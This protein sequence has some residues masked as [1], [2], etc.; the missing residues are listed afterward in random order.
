MLYYTSSSSLSFDVN[1]VLTQ[2]I[3]PSFHPPF[4]HCHTLLHQIAYYSCL[5]I[6]AIIIISTVFCHPRSTHS[7]LS[8]FVSSSLYPSSYSIPSDSV[9]LLLF[10]LCYCHHDGIFF[11]I[12]HQVHIMSYFW[13]KSFRALL[14]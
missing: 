8:T 9:L 4:I 3:L 7:V 1:V 11:K 6:S 10:H 14:L 2:F 12:P 13:S 5:F